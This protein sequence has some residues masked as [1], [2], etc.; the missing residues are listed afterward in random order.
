MAYYITWMYCY[1]ITIKK[2]SDEHIYINIYIYIFS[3]K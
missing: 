3:G 1:N 2:Q